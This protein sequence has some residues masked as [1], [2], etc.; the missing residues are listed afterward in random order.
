MFGE[1]WR[2]YFEIESSAQSLQEVGGGIGRKRAYFWS[3]I[4]DWTLRVKRP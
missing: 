3:V 4:G 2:R 1:A